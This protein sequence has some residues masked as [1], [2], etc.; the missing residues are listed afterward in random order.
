MLRGPRGD[1]IMM[2]VPLVEQGEKV[3]SVG[4][5]F[6]HGCCFGAPDA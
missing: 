3:K 4:E 5:N 2:G 1:T 6:A